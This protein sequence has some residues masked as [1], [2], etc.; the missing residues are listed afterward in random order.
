M[1]HSS[2]KR[3]YKRCKYETSIKLSCFNSGCCW[4]KAQT[5]NHCTDG[6]CV[7]SNSYL[8]P[9]TTVIVRIKNY[10]SNDSRPFNFEGLPTMAFGEVKWCRENPEV[11][12][13]LYEAGLKYYA[14]GY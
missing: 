14:P 4:V 6:M 11:N 13:S 9:G 2:E 12:L 10:T 5:L 8:Q 7:V 3:S 1:I